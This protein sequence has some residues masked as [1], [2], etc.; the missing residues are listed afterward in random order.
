[1]VTLCDSCD[2]IWSGAILFIRMGSYSMNAKGYAYGL[3]SVTN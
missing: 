1:M 2:T 3:D